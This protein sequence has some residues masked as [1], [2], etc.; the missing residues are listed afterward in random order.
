[1][2]NI[3]KSLI[4]R[5]DGE[6]LINTKLGGVHSTDSRLQPTQVCLQRIRWTLARCKFLNLERIDGHT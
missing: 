3:D 1:M 5:G 4:D 6:E 2:N